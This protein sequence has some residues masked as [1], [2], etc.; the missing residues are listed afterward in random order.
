MKKIYEKQVFNI[1]KT[2][3]TTKRVYCGKGNGF[4]V[5]D[6]QSG[7]VIDMSYADDGVEVNRSANS[8]FCKK[9]GKTLREDDKYIVYRANFYCFKAFCTPK[10]YIH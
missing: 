2:F 7:N 10:P 3:Y 4:I 8:K 9:P 1:P 6:K 5:V